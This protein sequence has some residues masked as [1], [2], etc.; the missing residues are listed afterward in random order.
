MDMMEDHRS[1]SE[2]SLWPLTTR[3]A[4]AATTQ[5]ASKEHPVRGS[6][7]SPPSLAALS[8]TSTDGD[9]HPHLEYEI[10]GV[11]ANSM[12]SEDEMAATSWPSPDTANFPAILDTEDCSSGILSA[13][14]LDLSET[15]VHSFASMA[16]LKSPT[17]RV[18][19]L[20]LETPDP[21]L[22]P[23]DAEDIKINRT[24][25][26]A[27][28]IDPKQLANVF[29]LFKNE[30]KTPQSYVE[31]K[32]TD[33]PGIRTIE[34][35]GITPAAVRSSAV[36]IDQ[37][38]L[39]SAHPWTGY[40]RN[41]KMTAVLYWKPRAE[42]LEKECETLK[43]IIS[44]DSSKIFQLKTALAAQSAAI[45]SLKDQLGSAKQDIEVLQKEKEVFAESE[46]EQEETIRIL[47]D[48]VDRLTRDDSYI[49]SGSIIAPDDSSSVREELEQLRLENQLFVS[50]IL[51]YEAELEKLTQDVEPL[52]K[53]A[54]HQLFDQEGAGR[55]LANDVAVSCLTP[56]SDHI[57]QKETDPASTK[58]N[59]NQCDTNYS[60]DCSA[61][62][63]CME[64]L[65]VVEVP[66]S[67]PQHI[68]GT[69]LGMFTLGGNGDA[70]DTEKDN[71]FIVVQQPEVISVIGSEID[72]EKVRP[73]DDDPA[74]VEVERI[75]ASQIE[76]T[77]PP[78]I[79]MEETAIE[80]L[81]N[82]DASLEIEVQLSP[83]PVRNQEEESETKPNSHSRMCDENCGAWNIFRIFS[84]DPH[85]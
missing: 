58:L 33:P 63:V 55:D 81:E 32:S 13:E 19:S 64:Q 2:T 59:R 16:T 8:L 15:S 56:S 44:V 9:D 17:G 6:P 7:E 65:A 47:K 78:E 24:C 20:D 74:S 68:V 22:E 49:T 77:D 72:A 18:S 83:Y 62:Q 69:V 27:L 3:S 48:E 37:P 43:E 35:A 29:A 60:A 23:I 26:G 84:S 42:T 54:V 67:T 71:G 14:E 66:V 70:D 53:E 30:P 45:E 31:K 61:A 12:L 57:D 1:V 80:V 46:T 5:V 76:D 39:H 4:L 28:N 34:L 85:E 41:Q 52:E 40:A 51:E 75:D 73:P 50:Q 21:V 36:A 82:H 11:L 25:H 79:V 10:P 38:T